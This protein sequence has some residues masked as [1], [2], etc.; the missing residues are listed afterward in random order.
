M[1]MES[2]DGDQ[3]LT[4]AGGFQVLFP[5]HQVH[6]SIHSFIPPTPVF[7]FPTK[8]LD[9]GFGYPIHFTSLALSEFLN[10]LCFY[11]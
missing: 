10:L 4:A 9:F 7:L 11:N 6:F 2:P 1:S 8:G 3:S 5:L